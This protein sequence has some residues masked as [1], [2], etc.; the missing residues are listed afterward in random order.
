MCTYAVLTPS[1]LEPGSS[2]LT[3]DH[4]LT[5]KQSAEWSPVWQLY[6]AFILKFWSVFLFFHILELMCLS[7][8]KE[9]KKKKNKMTIIYPM[10]GKFATLTLAPPLA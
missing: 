5:E 1:L 4:Y 8:M 7:P 2:T 3:F 6:C 9:K 10:V